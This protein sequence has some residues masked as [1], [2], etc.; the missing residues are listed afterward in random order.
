MKHTNVIKHLDM[1]GRKAEDKVTGFK[2]VV[3]SL[4]FDLYGCIQAVVSPSVDKDGKKLDAAVFDVS[5]LV[6]SDED[7]VMERPNWE[8]GL[9]AEAKH[10][11]AEKPGFDG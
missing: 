1:L 3:A 7:P 10:G 9:V 11:P 6:V 8:Y 4:Y 5:R 2:G